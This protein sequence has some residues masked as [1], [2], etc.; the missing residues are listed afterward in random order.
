MKD[1]LTIVAIAFI[2][3]V[4]AGI[5]FDT[6]KCVGTPARIRIDTVDRVV[7]RDVIQYKEAPAEIVYRDRWHYIHDT[8]KVT[9]VIREEGDT[10]FQT[11]AFTAVHDTVLPAGDSVR[12]SFTFPEQR[13][14]L[15][16]KPVPDT[17]PQI[18][19][20]MPEYVGP[21]IW[22]QIAT[23][24]GAAILGYAVGRVSQ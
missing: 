16:F 11:P 21:T 12:Q 8:V 18:T 14:S 20:Y 7:P 19:V 9:E 1:K 4:L 23:H 17:I 13:F 5:I 2:A 6:G 22:E 15:L 10:V 24:A 3:G